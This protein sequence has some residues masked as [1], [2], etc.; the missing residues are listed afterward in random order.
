MG[1]LLCVRPT[2]EAV[3]RVDPHRLPKVGLS[4][5]A[6]KNKMLEGSGRPDRS[7]LA[8]EERPLRT[9]SEKTPLL[10]PFTRVASVLT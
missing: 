6:R 7:C 8:N 3:E 1:F 2:E 4:N 9:P 10:N 5:G